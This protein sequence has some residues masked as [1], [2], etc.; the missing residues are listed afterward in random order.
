MS[1][2]AIDF[3]SV[4]ILDHPDPNFRFENQGEVVKAGEPLLIRHS[5][6]SNY[7]GAC[8]SSKYAND[9]G[10]ENEVHVANHSSLYRTQNL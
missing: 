2:G 5:Q 7:L 9:F 3:N 6:T 10:S 4:W 8:S 1:A